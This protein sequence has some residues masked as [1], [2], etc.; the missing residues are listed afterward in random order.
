M[1][2]FTSLKNVI[3]YPSKIHIQKKPE[4]KNTSGFKKKW[5]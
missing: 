1:K 5:R 2:N 4:V 3:Y